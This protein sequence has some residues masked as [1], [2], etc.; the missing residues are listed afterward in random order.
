MRPSLF[1]MAFGLAILSSTRRQFSRSSTL[2][3]MTNRNVV[4]SFTST[5]SNKN[6]GDSGLSGDTTSRINCN[7]WRS[8]SSTT[9]LK[10]HELLLSNTRSFGKYGNVGGVLMGSTLEDVDVVNGS[11]SATDDIEF[12]LMGKVAEEC[13]PRLR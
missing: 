2:A 10:N 13:P 4:R 7:P 6:I 1:S 5:I 9:S 11:A 3:F 8:S 12:P